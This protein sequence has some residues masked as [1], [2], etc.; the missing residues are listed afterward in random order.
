MNRQYFSFSDLE[1][2]RQMRITK[3]S[4]GFSGSVTTQRCGTRTMSGRSTRSSS[5]RASWNTRAADPQERTTHETPDHDQCDSAAFN[6]VDS[7]DELA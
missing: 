7:G 3:K 2:E 5:M 4:R 6:D 1:P